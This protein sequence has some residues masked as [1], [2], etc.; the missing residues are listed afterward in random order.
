M[1]SSAR[2][3]TFAVFCVGSIL[4]FS[5]F[6]SLLPIFRTVVEDSLSTNLTNKISAELLNVS[7][8]R[9]IIE[10][11]NFSFG[12]A[13]LTKTEIVNKAKEQDVKKIYADQNVSVCLNESVPI[14]KNPEQWRQIEENYGYAINGSG[15]KIAI[16]DT[17]IDKTH[18]DLNDL[19][20]NPAT[21][22][23][24][25]ILEQD[26][27]GCGHTYDD[28]GHGT[29]CAS[30][31]AGT[32]EASNYVYVGVAPGAWLM[33]GKVLDASGSGYNS[34]IIAG[35]Q[36]AVA[37]G[38]NII[39]L[40]L[41]GNCMTDDPL[42]QI[43]N[44]AVSQGVVVTVAAGNFGASGVG[45]VMSPGLAK[46]AITVGAT[47]KNGSLAGFSSY[48]PT[49]TNQ[50]KP[51]V[52]APGVGIVA[53][54]A[55]GTSLGTIV[56]NYY[57][58]LSGT[59]MATP[60]IAG[61]VA[62]LLEMHPTW[63]PEMV[64]AVLVE[65][66]TPLNYPEYMV[67][68]GTINVCNATATQAL[69]T[70]APLNFGVGEN[71]SFN[72]SLIT[73]S[74]QT[75]TFT[76]DLVS[77]TP[78]PA[79]GNATITFTIQP[80]PENV[81]FGTVYVTSAITTLRLPY[82]GVVN[83]KWANPGLSIIT[84]ENLGEWYAPLF[85]I[86]DIMYCGHY[87]SPAKVDKISLLNH[88]ILT[89][90][91]LP[92][93]RAYSM[94]AKNGF[95]YV[96]TDTCPAHIIKIDL[97]TFKVVA[98]LTCLIA[99]CPP[100]M[101]L[102][103]VNNDLFVSFSAIPA[104][105]EKID[106]LTFTETQATEYYDS[107]IST[108]MLTL[109]TRNGHLYAGSFGL[110]G[111]GAPKTARVVEIDP[112]TLQITR[113]TTLAENEQ[114]ISGLEVVGDTLFIALYGPNVLQPSR[115]VTLNIT[116]FT[117]TQHTILSPTD[118]RLWALTIMNNYVYAVSDQTGII[119]LNSTLQKTGN[120][121][122]GGLANT[123]TSYNG[124]LIVGERYSQTIYFVSVP[125]LGGET[126][127]INA[128]EG[129]A[130]NPAIGDHVYA[131]NTNITVTA[132]A[133]ANCI[134][135]NW[136]LD[137]V[138]ATEN[139]I[140]ILMDTNHTLQAVFTHLTCTLVITEMEGGTTTPAPGTHIYNIG[141]SV[142][143]TATPNEGYRFN[144]WTFDNITAGPNPLTIIM[145]ASHTL[146]A[147]FALTTRQLT[148]DASSYGTTNPTAGAYVYQ[149]GVNA[150]IT[151]RPNT[152]Y[153]FDGWLLNDSVV[154]DNPITITVTNDY[155]LRAIFSQLNYTLT[156]T[157][158]DGGTTS[159]APDIYFYINGSVVEVSAIPDTNYVFGGWELDGA[160]RTDNPLTLTM[161]ANHTIQAVFTLIT[162]KLTIL[163]ATGG[164][165]DPTA[166]NYTLG[167]GTNVTVTA[168]PNLNYHF[169]GWL[170]DGNEVNGSTITITMNLDHTLSPVFTAIFHLTIATTTGGS[171]DPAGDYTTYS[172][173]NGTTAT[174]TA[175]PQENYQFDY[176]MLNDTNVGSA[177][178]YSL[179]M[180][181]DYELK[182]YFSLINYTLIINS[183]TGGTTNPQAG[184][185]AYANGSV[186]EVSATPNTG[187]R[188]AYWLLDG[189]NV[190]NRSHLT[191]TITSNHTLRAVFAQVQYQVVIKV[192][193][194]L[195]HPLA[196]ATVYLNGHRET[197]D[198]NGTVTVYLS[199]GH[200][201]LIVFKP[202]YRPFFAILNI[203]HDT[204]INVML[205][206]FNWR[207]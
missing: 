113:S 88:T 102:A 100:A 141:S 170:L 122:F 77:A 68:G 150:T 103:I 13:N 23:P 21:N 161:N 19:D 156:L 104:V 83:K 5:L 36:W 38:A 145:D 182:A 174:V 67:G 188:F 14:I 42:S 97:S 16:L 29:H 61:A 35:V 7:S 108:G 10:Y 197:T 160:I 159:P 164:T 137:G 202:G 131:K 76:N 147:H 133:N 130:T 72:S 118:T 78:N 194:R 63:T 75:F 1:G 11:E 105:I 25:V 146:T 26:F 106:L 47:C 24:K 28:Y 193:D 205:Y 152:N 191:L 79:I 37:N 39:S 165:T 189:Y 157:V 30:I 112:S 195:N 111:K 64:K 207:F 139:P 74:P 121:N 126:L 178:P 59:S 93:D 119:V 101:S 136:V 92:Q 48:G 140:T 173:L 71:L 8:A 124:T 15:V 50:M 12:F 138:N 65:T 192:M 185:Y 144:Y 128:T 186:V 40:S 172:Y 60:H 53:A 190:G 52:C 116:S 3:G 49:F 200:Y 41:G 163:S 4:F 148:I 55:G 169:N 134:F 187:Y 58:T 125:M 27:T 51:E 46:D 120:F 57:I 117:E 87:T 34:W 17:G 56:N 162:Y 201:F 62:L 45:S 81:I 181:A 132:T 167:Y 2:I 109:A 123:I 43:V 142:S 33:N 89:T 177:N 176:W 204:T 20:D 82:F 158:T 91:S 179:L 18:P 107:K 168:Y 22:D 69:L 171:T 84:A 184:T 135:S 110:S 66:A 175:L 198:E 183:S 149:Y 73:F 151:A 166:G 90:L 129:G 199:A 9:V 96:G 203:S 94:A 99:D 115:I 127:S 85:V 44:W 70:P 31:A 6:A 114:Y 95:L 98:D 32:G 80:R 180:N 54:R 154:S 86:G 196:N 143:V 153:K 206:R 155:N